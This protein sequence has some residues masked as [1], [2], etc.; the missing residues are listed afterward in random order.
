MIQIL[1]NVTGQIEVLQTLYAQ[2]EAAREGSDDKMAE[3][4]QAMRKMAKG[5]EGGAAQTEALTQDCRGAGAADCRADQPRGR[6]GLCRCR[7]P[8]AAA[9]DR[10]AASADSGRNLGRASGKH[11]RPAGRP[12]CLDH[13][14]PRPVARYGRTGLRWALSRS[15]RDGSM[16]WAGFVDAVTTLLMVL[17]FVLTIFTVMQSMLRDT[18]STQNNQLSELNAQVAQLADALGLEQTRAADLT[19]QVGASAIQPG[20]GRGRGRPAGQPHRQADRG[21]GGEGRRTGGGAEPH[22]QL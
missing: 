6:L 3:I 22:R 18:I 7:K 10:R 17:M 11:C 15:R 13:G 4:A 16:I 5:L 14:D 8:D 19:T 1:D 21:S 9:V 20:R 2:A 12:D